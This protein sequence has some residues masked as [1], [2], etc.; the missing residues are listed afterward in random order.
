MKERYENPRTKSGAAR[1]NG[2]TRKMKR[3]C[4]VR[5]ATEL[6]FT[7]AI[8]DYQSELT[9]AARR[10]V[11]DDERAAELVQDTFVRA[12]RFRDKFERG[13]SMRAWL[14]CILRNLCI[15]DFR[16][17]QRLR[18]HLTRFGRSAELLHGTTPTPETLLGF[19]EDL[20]QRLQNA[21]A[22]L[23][24]DFRRCVRYVDLEGRS[25]RA[26]AQ[27]LGCPVGTVMSRLHR[28]RTVLRRALSPLAIEYG[29]DP[30]AA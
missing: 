27:A 9:R 26:A 3:A 15:N 19:D 25:Y 21:L 24:E 30:A 17:D 23:P 10:F 20:D 14:H 8:V 13:T 28:A 5:E 6:A 18:K 2:A 22:A 4:A 16:R 12:W 11:R 7:Q 29:L 1:V